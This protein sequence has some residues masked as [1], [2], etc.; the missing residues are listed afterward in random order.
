M[1]M[2]SIVLALFLLCFALLGLTGAAVPYLLPV[3]ALIAGILIL[4]GR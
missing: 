1:K 2:G 3:L 4:C